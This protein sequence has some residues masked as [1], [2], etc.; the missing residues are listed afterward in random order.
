[1]ILLADSKGPDQTACLRSPIQA[2]AVRTCSEGT[3]SLDTALFIF[4]NTIFSW[5]CNCHVFCQRV[6]LNNMDHREQTTFNVD[7]LWETDTILPETKK[8]KQN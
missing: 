5:P 1:M 6:L 7:N 8:H 4:P 3:F 2:F